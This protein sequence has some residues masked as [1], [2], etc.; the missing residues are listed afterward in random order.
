MKVSR[1]IIFALSK[2]L[3][4][5]PSPFAILAGRLGIGEDSLLS[6]LTRYKK[7]G[8]IRR[9]GAAMAHRKVGFTCNAL[10]LW[11]VPESK[12]ERMG[13]VFSVVPEVSHCYARTSYPNWPFN[14][15][16]MVH[17]RSR[18][19]AEKIIKDMAKKGK[20]KEYR[21]LYTVQEFNKTK[22]DLREIL[23]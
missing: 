20:L 22:S 15:Y 5:V 7:D 1:D 11:K 6:E 3:E 23:G 2:P 12:L 10:V 8:I 9:V 13:E 17:A 4:L 21:V 18:K 16:T 14:L 19:A